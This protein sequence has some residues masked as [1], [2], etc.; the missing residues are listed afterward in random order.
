MFK[1]PLAVMAAIA[2]SGAA[3]ASASAAPTIFAN[4][5]GAFYNG[6]TGNDVNELTLVFSPTRYKL[7]GTATAGANCA[8]SGA[9]IFCTYSGTL[10][11]EMHGD[12]GDDALLDVLQG[13]NTTVYGDDGSDHL[14]ASGNA[15]NAYGGDGNDVSTT[16]SNGSGTNYGEAGSDILLT[17]STAL[18]MQGGDGDDFLVG[19]STFPV[20]AQ[21]NAG[22]DR[23]VVL[24]PGG[25]LSGG[26]EDDIV[27]FT[28]PSGTTGF[29]GATVHG[30]G[31]NDRL[32]GSVKPDKVY[33]DAGD[34]L[35]DTY[36]DGQVDT[37]DCGADNDTAYVD[38]IDTTTNCETVVVGSAAPADPQVSAALSDAAT[39]VATAWNA[40][41]PLP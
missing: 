10:Y 5:G 23:I 6:T 16:S 28:T 14:Y 2:L 36:G 32:Y 13:G 15:A 25:T 26:A 33:G 19:N 27:A 21:G 41:T 11:G 40:I 34:D 12:A 22:A 37:V 35:I 29:S 38:A 1:L 31:G 7:T 17:K 8:P 20:S 30:D 4:A 3:A 39:Y 9:D 18:S 24:K